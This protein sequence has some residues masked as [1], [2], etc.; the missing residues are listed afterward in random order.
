MLPAS[1]PPGFSTAWPTR[2]P[3]AVDMPPAVVVSP[4]GW[5]NQ[6]YA[7]ELSARSLRTPLHIAHRCR[8]VEPAPRSRFRRC[9]RDP[10]SDQHRRPQHCVSGGGPTAERVSSP[11]PAAMLVTDLLTR[12]QTPARRIRRLGT[13]PPHSAGSAAVRPTRSGNGPGRL[14]HQRSRD[15]DRVLSGAPHQGPSGRLEQHNVRP[16]QNA[17]PA[18]LTSFRTP[19]A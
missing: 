3:V 16:E 1:P 9:C 5:R 7:T 2:P 14:Q 11:A 4:A 10:G 13:P 17:R 6:L 18:P 19:F 12:R 8:T 15:R